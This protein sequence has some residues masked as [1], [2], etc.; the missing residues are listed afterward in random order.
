MSSIRC[1]GIY[2]G[3]YPSYTAVLGQGKLD[4]AGPGEVLSWGR[5]ISISQILSYIIAFLFQTWN[6][7]L[8]V[9]DV[10]LFYYSNMLLDDIPLL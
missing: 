8:V 7:S 10:Q 6:G 4:W 3:N 9:I 1:S 2:G 5:S